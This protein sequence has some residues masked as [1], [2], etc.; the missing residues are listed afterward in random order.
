MIPQGIKNVKI[1]RVCLLDVSAPLNIQLERSFTQLTQKLAPH[2]KSTAS[3]PD[4][5]TTT[6]P[7]I[8]EREIL[9][10]SAC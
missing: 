10:G 5:Q 2:T 1:T 9:K 6:N 4:I 7:F 3:S 8:Q